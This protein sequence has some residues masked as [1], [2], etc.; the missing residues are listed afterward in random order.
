MIDKK[1]KIIVTGGGTGG[2]VVPLMVVVSE[3]KKHDF[4]ILFVGSGIDLEKKA[5]EKENIKYKSVLSGK[6]RRYFSLE[7]FIDPFK[8]IIGFLQSFWIILTSRPK[9]IFAKGGYVTYPVVLAGWVL[10]VPIITHESDIVMG[11][12][13]KWEAKLARKVCVGFPLENY[14]DIPLDKIVYT[15]NPVRK[16]FNNSAMKPLDDTPSTRFGTSRGR[17]FDNETKLPIILVTGGSQ[18]ARFINQT[19]AALLNELTKKYHI[20]H[21]AGKNDYQWLSKNRWPNYELYDFTEN[22]PE[23]MKKSDLIITRA[24]ANTLAEISALG[25]SSIL[26]PLPTSAN[27]HQM[28]NA[29]LYEKNNAAIVLSE[30]SLSPDNLKSIIDHLVLDKK[31]LTEIGKN[32]KNLSQPNSAEAIIEEIM[33]TISN[34]P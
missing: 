9:V 18:G 22:M 2:H 4:D 17:Q 10:G 30:K 6:Y 11:M 24:G 32:A 15:G 27:N 23:L 28:I 14:K 1:T 12:A 16:Q 8:I 5:A 21:I 19:I 13:N 34:K 3:L 25:K 7:N 20:I 26:I 33:K 29:K 31:M